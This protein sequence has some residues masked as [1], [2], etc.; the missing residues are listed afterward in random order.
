M[1]PSLPVGKLPAELLA[2]LLSQ[3]PRSDP[4]VVIGP[5][6]GL[7]AA[8]IDMGDHYL[9]AKTDPITFATDDIGWYAVNV[10]A[11]DIACMGAQPKWFMVS[12][13]LPPERADTA[14][15]E[16]IFKQITEACAALDIALVGGHTE[17]TFD[18][19]RPILVGAMLGE[20]AKDKLVTSRGAR[21]GDVVLLTKAVPLEG[22]ALIAREKEDDLKKRGF[23]DDFLARAKNLLRIP[24]ISVVR[25]ALIAAEEGAATAM[26]D[27]TEG[28]LATGLRELAQA[29]QA[30]LALDGDA[31]PFLKEGI[32]LCAAYRLDPLGVIA[33]GS[34]LLTTP[35]EKANDLINRFKSAGVECAAIGRVVPAEEGLTI[36]RGGVVGQLPRFE[37]DEVARLFGD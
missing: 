11:N 27:P 10:N 26:H 5:G 4:R 33:S 15:A 14:M 28:G 24:G 32:E 31:I 21:S 20:V 2:T 34:L 7:D 1:P 36:T 16:R 30:G 29:S 3:L 8:V 18:L 17:I 6:I 23:S 19:N 37:V 12:A 25:E 13:L 22:T 9:V 35:A